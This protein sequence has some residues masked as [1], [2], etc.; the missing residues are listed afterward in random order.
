MQVRNSQTGL[1]I[2]TIYV[3]GVAS[4]TSLLWH[5]YWELELYLK[6]LILIPQTLLFTV[7]ILTIY[8]QVHEVRSTRDNVIFPH[9]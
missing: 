1:H 8:T 2:R 9:S 7:Q 5:L 6:L 3:S 4:T